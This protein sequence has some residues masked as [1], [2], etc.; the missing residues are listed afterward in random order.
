[1]EQLLQGIHDIDG[2][3]QE[4]ITLQQMRDNLAES[5]DLIFRYYTSSDSLTDEEQESMKLYQNI[6]KLPDGS[7]MYGIIITQGY[8]IYMENITIHDI[9]LKTKEVIG[10]NFQEC[11]DMNYKPIPKVTPSPT[12]YEESEGATPS[13]TT[14]RAQPKDQKDFWQWYQDYYNYL[15][16]NENRE[17][18]GG[19]E[20]ANEEGDSDGS[21]RRLLTR[22]RFNN[23]NEHDAVCTGPFGEVMDVT[24]MIPDDQVELITGYD[25]TQDLSDLDYIG[26]PLSDAQ[27][28][29]YLN[30]GDDN[31]NYA[32]ASF[33]STYF[34]QWAVGR[35]KF[36]SE[37]VTFVRNRD[38]MNQVNKG[39]VGV[40]M[41]GIDDVMINNI[42]IENLENK[43]EI[44]DGTN[45]RGISVIDGD[46]VFMS[47]RVLPS[48]IVKI[49]FQPHLNTPFRHYLVTRECDE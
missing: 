44:V 1:M 33:I 22:I 8:N 4:Y 35:M 6:D 12:T 10:M 37:C 11:H 45:V 48:F 49:K 29:L 25:G 27:I 31:Y 24:K 16:G 30:D 19:Y 18:W 9:A 2:Q 13:P 42:T 23:D 43:A 28:A 46:L 39:I 14:F 36:P 38:N 17:Y 3:E 47:K 5:M 7:S 32:K 20:G 26:N 40:R 15:Y 34:L 41:D 21:R